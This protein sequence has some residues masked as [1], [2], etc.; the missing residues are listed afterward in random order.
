M[1][2]GAGADLTNASRSRPRV[3]KLGG[4]KIFAAAEIWSRIAFIP[5][6]YKIKRQ[7][8]GLISF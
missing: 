5:L 8:A 3:C 2:E 1:I 4:D 7:E 6:V